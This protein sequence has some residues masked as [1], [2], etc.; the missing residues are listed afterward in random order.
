MAEYVRIPQNQPEMISIDCTQCKSIKELGMLMNGL[1]LAVTEEW[2][3]QNNLEHILVKQ[4]EM[5]ELNLPDLE[6]HDR[7]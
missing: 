4:P 2:A 1:G 3:K 6:P 5:I 7:M